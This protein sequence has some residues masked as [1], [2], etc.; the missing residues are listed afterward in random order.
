MD[1]LKG[2]IFIYPTTGA[3]FSDLVEL[4]SENIKDRILT[5]LRNKDN[6]GKKSR[7]KKQGDGAARP[8]AAR[9]ED[10]END[11]GLDDKYQPDG[12][13]HALNPLEAAG[14]KTLAAMVGAHG[15]P[16]VAVLHTTVV[17]LVIK[18]EELAVEKSGRTRSTA[19]GVKDCTKLVMEAAAAK[20]QPMGFMETTLRAQALA[21]QRPENRPANPIAEQ[22]K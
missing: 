16:I 12:N 8:A 1:S 22:S 17:K 15:G 4:T 11:D 13:A 5:V 10:D 6:H 2:K 14:A 3:P 20:G 21:R 7:K 9:K 18:V 19:Q